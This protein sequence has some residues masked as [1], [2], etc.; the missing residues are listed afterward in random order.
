MHENNIIKIFWSGGWDSTFR[1]LQ[2]VL[3]KKIQVQPYYIVDSERKSMLNELEAMQKIKVEIENKFPEESK[4][5]LP[6]NFFALFSIEK[7]KVISDSH[8]AIQKKQRMGIQYEWLARFCAQQKISEMEISLEL[9]TKYSDNIVIN[10]SG[11]HLVEEEKIQGKVFKISDKARGTD[12]HNLFGYMIFPV[13]DLTKTQ[14]FVF[15]QKQGFSEILAKSWFC[16]TPTKNNSPCGKCQPCRSVVTE[17]LSWRL[18]RRAKIRYY[19]W[20]VLRKVA[21]TFQFNAI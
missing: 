18:N 10:A 4:N 3:I 1:I 15:S 19:I 17:G 7:N 16:H 5:L 13:I 9:R 12:I 14:M 20:P 6:T 21:K 11:K 8:A 2:L